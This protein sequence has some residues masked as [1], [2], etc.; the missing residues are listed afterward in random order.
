MMVFIGAGIIVKDRQRMA[1][2][3]EEVVV[4]ALVIKIMDNLQSSNHG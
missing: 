3:D 1:R 4:Q 2:F